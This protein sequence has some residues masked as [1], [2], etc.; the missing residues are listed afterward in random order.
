[1]HD[2]G[3]GV[4]DSVVDVPASGPVA[5]IDPRTHPTLS[6]AERPFYEY[7]LEHVV[8]P[9]DPQGFACVTLAEPHE[10]IPSDENMAV[11]SL[12]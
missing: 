12:M 11:N 5:A 8:D 7:W 2:N 9:A 3:P 10:V 6:G 4:V 1:M